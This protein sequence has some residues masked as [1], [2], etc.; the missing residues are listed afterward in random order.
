MIRI[1]FFLRLGLDGIAAAC[2]LVGLAYYWLDNAVH[3][4][5]GTA[6][7]VLVIAHNVFNRLWWGHVKKTRE[8]HRWLDLVLVCALL[9]GML[10]LMTSSVLISQTIFGFLQPGGGFTARQIHAFAGHWVVLLVSI[11]I[12]IRWKRLMHAAH[13]LMHLPTDSPS[14]T[15]ALRAAAAAIA[16]YGFYSSLVLGVGAKLTMQMSLE[17]WDFEAST[18]GFFAHWLAVIG[19]YVCVAHYAM[20]YLQAAQRRRYLRVAGPGIKPCRP[21]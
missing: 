2:L 12:G 6:M 1:P 3:E 20:T 13:A 19:L 8:P 9:G 16:A 11:H 18:T 17:W 21:T 7:F 4:V 15:A 14:R 5:V 10:T